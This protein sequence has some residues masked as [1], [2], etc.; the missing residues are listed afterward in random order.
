MKSLNVSCFIL[1]KLK[2]RRVN[3]FLMFSLYVYRPALLPELYRRIAAELV[4]V[5][6]EIQFFSLSLHLFIISKPVG[7]VVTQTA[8]KAKTCTLPSSFVV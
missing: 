2:L 4:A 3:N 8:V 6:L 7:R 5:L 1:G